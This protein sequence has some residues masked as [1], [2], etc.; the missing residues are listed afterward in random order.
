[1]A[2][3]DLPRRHDELLAEYLNRLNA[4]ER[5]DPLEVIA[6]HPDE[7]EELLADLQAFLQVAPSADGDTDPQPV[8]LGDYTLRR[9]L[10]RG[11]MGVVYEAWENSM[12]RRVAVK[13]L[14]SAVAA[15][16][17]TFLR[18]CREARLAGSLHHP[19]IVPVFGMGIKGDTPHYAM[20]LVE[21]ETLAQHLSRLKTAETKDLFG[22]TVGTPACYSRLA[23]V[24]AGV[25]EGLQHA[26][27]KRIIH[28]DLKPSNLILDE[29]GRLRILDFGLARP[30]RARRA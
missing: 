13:V 5:I 7:G 3:S 10:G 14:P 6:S 1:M 27:S 12:D 8:T 29:D 26:H 23:E 19:H 20:E 9:R 15:D 21:G 4:G 22:F 28:R 18:F 24:F 11:G 2:D 17:K 30:S 25:A 16:Q